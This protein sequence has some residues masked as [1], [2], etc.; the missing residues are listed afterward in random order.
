MRDLAKQDDELV[1]LCS[2]RVGIGLYLYTIISKLFNSVVD[3]SQQCYLNFDSRNFNVVMYS[4]VISVS[5]DV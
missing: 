3:I 4:A 1:Y 5:I 2:C